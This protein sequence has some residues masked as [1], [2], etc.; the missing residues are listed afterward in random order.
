MKHLWKLVSGLGVLAAG[1]LAASTLA[2]AQLPPGAVSNYAGASGNGT[3]T[4][5]SGVQVNVIFDPSARTLT[6]FRRQQDGRLVQ[7]A[8]GAYNLTN[9]GAIRVRRGRIVWDAFGVVDRLNRGIPVSQPGD[10]G[11]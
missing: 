11:G 9:G 6:A 4:T 10:N 7:L 2:S 1:A 5:T 3:L 8:D